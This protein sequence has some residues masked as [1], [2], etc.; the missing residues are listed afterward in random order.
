V[1]ATA[2]VT[3]TATATVAATATWLIYSLCIVPCG[4]VA[5][6][7][8][9]THESGSDSDGDSDSDS[10][11]RGSSKVKTYWKIKFLEHRTWTGLGFANVFSTHNN[12]SDSH[13]D[14]DS[15][16]DSDSDKAKCIAKQ[17]PSLRRWEWGGTEE[18]AEGNI[19][20]TPYGYVSL[21]AKEPYNQW[22]FCGKRRAIEGILCIVTIL[23]KAKETVREWGEGRLGGGAD[24]SDRPVTDWI[25]GSRDSLIAW[26]QYT[27]THCNTLQHTFSDQREPQPELRSRYRTISELEN[28]VLEINHVTNVTTVLN[29][30]AAQVGV[31][32]NH[33]T[34]VTTVLN[35]TAAQVGV[36]ARPLCTFDIWD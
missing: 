23:S 17:S 36:L 28:S 7:V 11:S 16:S 13:S 14:R 30:T 12:D 15:D 6:T 20:W 19:H 18:T 25:T 29:E 35:E 21:S 8:A 33:V 5:V 9:I 3:A 2:T 1:A 26:L 24:R 27:A 10:D 34:N 31:E 22:L 32:I 4:C